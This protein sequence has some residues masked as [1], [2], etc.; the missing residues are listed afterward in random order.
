MKKINTGSSRNLKTVVNILQATLTA[1]PPGIGY[2]IYTMAHAKSEI[3]DYFFLIILMV[4]FVAF[5]L[6]TFSLN[7]KLDAVDNTKQE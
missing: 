6:L 2:L 1:I 3:I 7:D 5:L 4:I